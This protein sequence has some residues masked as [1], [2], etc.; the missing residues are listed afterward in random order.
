MYSHRKKES[1]S[2]TFFTEKL[3]LRHSK[4]AMKHKPGSSDSMASE[5]YV[6]PEKG[7]LDLPR[8]SLR[9]LFASLCLATGPSASSKCKKLCAP[10][11]QTLEDICYDLCRVNTCLPQNPPYTVFKPEKLVLQIKLLG[12]AKFSLNVPPPALSPAQPEMTGSSEMNVNDVCVTNDPFIQ[13]LPPSCRQVS[14]KAS[15]LGLVSKLLPPGLISKNARYVGRSFW[16]WLCTV[17]DL[18]EK[19]V[20][21]EWSD[22]GMSRI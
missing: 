12:G 3:E 1:N 5:F 22:T 6:D 8:P 10:G 19:L 14:E 9:Y 18:T 16:T 4:P 7:M 13:L 2:I 20:G 11:K 21:K 17:D 15:P